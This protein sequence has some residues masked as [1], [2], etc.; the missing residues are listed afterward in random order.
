MKV[1][2]PLIGHEQ[3]ASSG[4]HRL[5][6]R[7]IEHLDICGIQGLNCLNLVRFSALSRVNP[8]LRGGLAGKT[9]TH[10]GACL[11]VREERGCLDKG[12]T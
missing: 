6:P 12:N 3:L 4:A 7:L 11:V 5:T 2:N 9:R 10:S 8:E 1:D